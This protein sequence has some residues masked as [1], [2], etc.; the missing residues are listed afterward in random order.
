M[1]ALAGKSRATLVRAIG[2]ADCGVLAQSPIGTGD[3]K[4]P[5][6]GACGVQQKGNLS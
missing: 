6:T 3:G 4:S 1:Q 2:D 5:T